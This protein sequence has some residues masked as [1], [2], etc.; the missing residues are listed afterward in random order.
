MRCYDGELGPAVFRN[1]E[2][3]ER[4]F[5]SAE[6]GLRSCYIRPSSTAIMARWV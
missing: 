3:G 5:R 4:L 1:A 6:L 2:G